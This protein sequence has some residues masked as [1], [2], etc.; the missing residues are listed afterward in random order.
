MNDDKWIVQTKIISVV[1]LASG[2]AHLGAFLLEC[3]ASE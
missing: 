2:N 3:L 1:N